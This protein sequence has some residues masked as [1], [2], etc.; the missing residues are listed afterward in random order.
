MFKIVTAITLALLMVAISGTSMNAFAQERPATPQDHLSLPLIPSL[1]PADC[2]AVAL[3][4]TFA[5]DPFC[6]DTLF[7]GLC[8]HRFDQYLAQCLGDAEPGLCLPVGGELLPID[9]TALILAGAQTNAVW[10][11]SALAVIGSVAFGALY[12]TTRRN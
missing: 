7:D 8:Q 2:E 6:E 1:C 5:D 3:A 10:M 9:S 11:I 12:L 4:N